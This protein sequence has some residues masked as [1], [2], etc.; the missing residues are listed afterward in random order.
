MQYSFRSHR[1]HESTGMSL[2]NRKRLDERTFIEM[3][4][5]LHNEGQRRI[6]AFEYQIDDGNEVVCVNVLINSNSLNVPVGTR[7]I[8]STFEWYDFL[9]VCTVRPT[10]A[11]IKAAESSQVDWITEGF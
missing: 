3:L 11:Q 5:V 4:A 1:I 2:E 6:I 8:I 7:F 9:S 10:R